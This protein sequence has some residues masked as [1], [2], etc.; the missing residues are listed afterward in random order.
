MRFISFVLLFWVLVVGTLFAQAPEKDKLDG[1][2]RS[3]EKAL[4]SLE[5]LSMDCERTTKDRVFET[6]EKSRGTAKIQ[7]A[8]APK[9]GVR[10]CLEMFREVNGKLQPD[11]F[12]KYLFTGIAL[13]DYA[14]ADKVIRKIPITSP[15]TA[16]AAEPAENLLSLLF[17]KKSS[18][19]FARYELTYLPRSDKHYFY[20]K[21][22]PKLAQDKADFTEAH[23]ALYQSNFLAAMIHL[24]QPNGNEVTWRFQNIQVNPP[25]SEKEFAVPEPPPPGWQLQQAPSV[26][27]AGA[28]LKE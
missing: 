28:A 26:N 3:W 18:D 23:V 21:V 17:G 8:S 5:G 7:R 1:I 11:R 27:A 10:W 19:L 15:V 24:R 2:V 4:S 25:L 20:V 9:K 22:V 12:E 16:S 6:T 14:P 13:Y